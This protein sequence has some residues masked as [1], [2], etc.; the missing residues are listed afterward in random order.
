MFCDFCFKKENP[1]TKKT[2][3]KQNK[4]HKNI[5]ANKYDSFGENEK[6][7]EKHDENEEEESRISNQEFQ[8]RLKI[9]RSLNVHKSAITPS[10]ESSS[11]ILQKN[12][13]I[14][15]SQKLIESPTKRLKSEGDETDQNQIAV[16]LEKSKVF[17]R[18]N[19]NTKLDTLIK[20][21]N[22]E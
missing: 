17:K 5:L 3:I 8:L 19:S 13:K 12:K 10:L 1:N 21:G 11:K 18:R 9:K 2:T 16:S 20:N 22:S 7:I 4:K 6:I 15:T 14:Q